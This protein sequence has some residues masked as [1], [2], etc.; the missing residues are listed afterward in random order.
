MQRHK[1]VKI[2]GHDYLYP[3]FDEHIQVLEDFAALKKS[4]W[5]LVALLLVQP[6]LQGHGQL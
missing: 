3:L 2:K 4:V 1:D 5:S 6:I